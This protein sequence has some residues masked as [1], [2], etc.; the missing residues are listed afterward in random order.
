MANVF[1]TVKIQM[2]KINTT[3]TVILNIFLCFPRLITRIK[4]SLPSSLFLCLCNEYK[5]YA[6]KIMFHLLFVGSF[7][8][9]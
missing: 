3:A 2:L 9:Y 8:L 7:L 6:L 5:E 4:N 1:D